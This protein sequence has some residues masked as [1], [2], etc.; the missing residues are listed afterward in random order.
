MRL[1]VA[2]LAF[3]FFAPGQPDAARAQGPSINANPNPATCAAGQGRTVITWNAGS[4]STAEVWLSIDDAPEIL[5][6]GESRE[7][8]QNA[9]WIDGG[10]TY[11]FRLY[12][13][14]SHSSRLGSVQV[15]CSSEPPFIR[16]TPNPALTDATGLNGHTRI[17]WN[18]GNGR[19]GNVVVSIN[20]GKETLVTQGARGSVDAPYIRRDASFQ[21]RLYDNSDLVASVEVLPSMPWGRA[22][23]WVT[24]AAG[25]LFLIAGSYT[26]TDRAAFRQKVSPWLAVAMSVAALLPILSAQARP[27]DRQPYPDSHEYADGAR[28]LVSGKGY[29]TY[30]HDNDTWPDDGQA[31]PPRYPPGFSLALVPF[32][33]LGTYPDVVLGAAK[34]FAAFYVIVVVAAAWSMAG[35][36]A[37][38]IAAGLV[39]ISPF[40]E[41]SAVVLLADTFGAALTVLLVPLLNKPTPFRSALAGLVAGC[42]VLVKFSMIVN[43]AALALATR[44]QT[45]RRAL[46]FTAPALA[47]LFLYQWLTFGGPLKTGYGY[48]SPGRDRFSL[49]HAT[50]WSERP[51][52]VAFSDLMHGKLMQGVCPCPEAG[53]QLALP[54]IIFYPAVLAG[55]FWI[56]S[57]P[58]VT[59]AALFYFWR[60]WRDPPVTAAI[61][62]IA[63]TFALYIGHVYQSERFVA[64]AATLLVV[65]AAVT[66]AGW[67]ERRPIGTEAGPLGPAKL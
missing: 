25:L 26:Q 12:Q 30:V 50:G 2:V 14:S 36:L 32:A 62:I 52:G 60:R 6:G 56:F 27:L 49:S 61:C 54:S 43:I 39:G 63:L 59:I 7:G 42:S 16:A 15:R 64:S 33:A 28:Q 67:I 55:F 13:G 23:A 3:L 11:D 44:G 9:D 46:L 45:R 5:F 24:F 22:V 10:R 38:M 17:E 20:G 53:P 29:V 37:A 19:S 51:Q 48:W 21:F 8:T 40:G 57:P 31:R 4:G 47:G 65:F 66:I 18:T 34:W 1:S 58:L 35:P 41:Q